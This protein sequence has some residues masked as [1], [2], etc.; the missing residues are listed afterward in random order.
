MSLL[1]N[2]PHVVNTMGV[3]PSAQQQ[4]LDLISNNSL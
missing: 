4:R 1:A 2:D 3:P